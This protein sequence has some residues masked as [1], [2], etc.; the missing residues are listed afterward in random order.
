MACVDQ[1]RFDGYAQIVDHSPRRK[2]KLDK[3]VMVH[4]PREIGFK[5]GD[6]KQVCRSDL[7]YTFKQKEN[8]YQ[9]SL[10]HDGSSAG[11]RAPTNSKY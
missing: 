8:S 2:A 9:N 7:D 6:L 1:Q 11:T 5:A 4:T 10:Y 3:Q